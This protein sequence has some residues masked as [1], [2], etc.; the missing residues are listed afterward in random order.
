MPGGANMPLDL[1]SL[2]SVLQTLN[3]ILTANGQT[4]A[5]GIAVLASPANY[6]VA[7]LPASGASGQFAFATN[8]RKPGEGVGSGT[9]VPVFFNSHTGT[10]F[11]YC[12]GAVVTS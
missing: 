3:Q 11:S 12:S 8:G 1:T 10:W 2:V 6:T 9:G 5:D 4:M 7:T